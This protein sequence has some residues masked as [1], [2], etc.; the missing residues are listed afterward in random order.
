M[1]CRITIIDTLGEE[2]FTSRYSGWFPVSKIRKSIEFQLFKKFSGS[3]SVH[4]RWGLIWSTVRS[5]KSNNLRVDQSWN[6]INSNVRYKTIP[7]SY[8]VAREYQLWNIGAQY[9]SRRGS[10]IP[11]RGS[12]FLQRGSDVRIRG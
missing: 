10:V 11:H 1:K 9:S 12:T 4:G 6:S 5:F 7:T 2:A 8:M 3:Q